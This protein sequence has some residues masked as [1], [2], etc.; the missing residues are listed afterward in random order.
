V[1]ADGK[2]VLV[3]TGLG[4]SPQFLA[5]M[6]DAAVR[7]EEIDIVIHTHLHSDHTG[8]NMNRATNLPVFPNA[9]FFAPRADWDHF[10]PNPAGAQLLRDLEPIRQAGKLELFRG[11]VQLTPSMK[12]FATPGHTPGHTSVLVTSG[13][14]TAIILG[15]VFI[16]TFQVEA[17]DL[18]FS[19]DMD[20]P[21]AVATRQSLLNRAASD[22]A[23]V[24]A[25]H[26]PPPWMGKVMRRD[27][28]LV[29]QP[30]A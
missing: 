24:S 2:R 16:T 28:G 15:D 8:G 3:D 22:G 7:P 5:W 27:A 30:L 10:A 13:G 23:I 25:Y 26:L 4:Q 20:G 14:Q 9:R 21:T 1:N 11:E 6:R 17:P 19:G 29:W 18:V 12:T